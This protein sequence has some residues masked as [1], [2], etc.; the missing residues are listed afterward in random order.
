MGDVNGRCEFA[1]VRRVAVTLRFLV[2][3][4]AVVHAHRGA[5]QAVTSHLRGLTVDDLLG[6]STVGAVRTSPDGRLVAFE[7]VR[8]SRDRHLSLPYTSF[9]RNEIWIAAVVGHT[10]R[11]LDEPSADT[12][13]YMSPRWSPDGTRLAFLKFGSLKIPHLY[14]WERRTGRMRQVCQLPVALEATFAS[15]HLDAD[16]FYW[17]ND[18]SITFLSPPETEAA[19]NVIDAF[20]NAESTAVT[21]WHRTSIGEGPNVIV[22]ESG[23]AP[24]NSHSV[25]WVT[26]ID[27][28][29]GRPQS[30]SAIPFGTTIFSQLIISHSDRRAA[31]LLGGGACEPHA[32]GSVLCDTKRS[33][34]IVSFTGSDS[35]RW[36]ST[37]SLSDRPSATA[38]WSADDRYLLVRA[39][40]P[41]GSERP[42]ALVVDTRSLS[43]KFIDSVDARESFW[44]SDSLLFARTENGTKNDWLTLDVSGSHVSLASTVRLGIRPISVGRTR[45]LDL[46]NGTLRLFSTA[47]P[48]SGKRL[49]TLI[50]RTA[51]IQR[52]DAERDANGWPLEIFVSTSTRH[53]LILVDSALR[54]STSTIA[55]PTNR[56]QLISYSPRTET[57]LFNSGEGAA[58]P[59]LWSCDLISARSDTILHLN[60]ALD[61]ITAGT[62]RLITYRGSNGEQLHGLLV[63]PVD[64]Q[65]ARHYPLIV[66]VYA[67]WIQEDTTSWMCDNNS[68]QPLDFRL[69]TARGY[70]VLIPSIPLATLSSGSD[71]FLEITA[72]V[73]A[74]I[75]AAVDQG[76]VDSARVGVIGHSFGGYTTFALLANT[77][78]FR[79]AVAMAGPSNLATWSS[80]LTVP[81]RY[82]THA[83]PIFAGN[84]FDGAYGQGGLGAPSNTDWW[85]YIRNSP[86]YFADR[87]HTPL[88]IMQGDMDYV[89][90]EQGEE[91]FSML[92]QR[93][94]RARLLRYLGEGHIIQSPANVRDLWRNV[95]DWF[96][97][98]LLSTDSS[99]SA[100]N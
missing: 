56:S 13:G 76:S 98:Y 20:V 94:R 47:W 27:V 21:A 90:P 19:S 95:F 8:P 59:V 34:G 39:R 35:I 31:V 96:E 25:A 48:D 46:V 29:T 41:S 88:L 60:L 26:T 70:A 97:T 78:R 100:T 40:V 69:L 91:L 77:Q 63:L 2:A 66:W 1:L 71:P 61:S 10:V 9:G 83:Q 43:T 50:D 82:A 28:A 79:A 74:A 64:Y 17:L 55:C 49:D 24:S 22:A 42:C 12:S 53:E 87:I 51:T 73:L 54:V 14:V 99:V 32:S 45:Y 18:S 6:T 30:R 38:K 58:G 57:V 72:P 5:A 37:E 16:Y 7:Y 86:V 33:L 3:L 36:V 15:A 80:V 89:P 62:R 65:P 52:V 4:V 11:R 81:D 44:L 68:G 92:Y 75:D 67:G 93:G 23:Q 84:L 85:R